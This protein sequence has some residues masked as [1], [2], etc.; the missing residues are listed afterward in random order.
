MRKNE[1]ADMY[2]TKKIDSSN[3]HTFG[4]SNICNV[5]NL[6]TR[7]LKSFFEKVEKETIADHT[8]L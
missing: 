4:P 3:S 5:N 8:L 1:S 7:I 6:K 2:G